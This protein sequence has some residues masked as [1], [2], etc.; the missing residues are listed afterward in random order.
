MG[1][2]N[3]SR[4][5]A[6]ISGIDTFS[7]NG[8]V[9][10]VYTEG[11]NVEVHLAGNETHIDLVKISDNQ[12]VLSI[13][14]PLPTI[15]GGGIVYQDFPKKV[16]R[17]GSINGQFYVNDWAIATEDKVDITI[18][19]PR[20]IAKLSITLKYVF[21]KFNVDCPDLSLILDSHYQL[22]FVAT[23]LHSIEVNNWGIGNVKIGDIAT[24]ANLYNHSVGSIRCGHVK[25]N[26][27][28]VIEGTGKVEFA[29]CEGQA[30]F[31]VEGVGSVIGES[32]HCEALVIKL[33]GT[34]RCEIKSGSTK[35]LKV[36]VGSVGAAL[37]SGIVVKA[38]KLVELINTGTGAIKL[39]TVESDLKLSTTGVGSI[40]IGSHNQGSLYAR[41]DGTGNITIESGD[42]GVADIHVNGIGKFNHGGTIYG[43]TLVLTSIGSITV[44]SK[45]Q[46]K[47][48]KSSIGKANVTLVS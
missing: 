7:L 19:I 32:I 6:T 47:V 41:L 20:S 23:S 36:M 13:I 42:S 16:T 17:S 14:G 12:G 4:T 28:V 25:Q 5:F 21:D 45:N 29:D 10:V 37:L 34:G 46:P 15:D 30:S 40:T 18:L 2:K 22:G 26:L 38:T 31:S 8:T 1:S 3:S 9:N 11:P 39:G 27:I 48:S 24:N 43:G 33:T 35:E 44:K